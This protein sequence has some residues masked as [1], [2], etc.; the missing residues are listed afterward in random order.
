MSFEED[1]KI[2]PFRWISEKAEKSWKLNIKKAEKGEKV[3]HFGS[4]TW[5]WMFEGAEKAERWLSVKA[6][7]QEGCESIKSW[8]FW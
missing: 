8:M 1:L 5:S 3:E 2:L 6:E 4:W 7:E